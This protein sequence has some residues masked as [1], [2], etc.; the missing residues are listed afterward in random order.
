[1]C[2][3]RLG[4]VSTS[5]AIDIDWSINHPDY[6]EMS[7]VRNFEERPS[8]RTPAV[9]APRGPGDGRLPAV[10]VQADG[11]GLAGSK[12]RIPLE[13]PCVHGA[14]VARR[15]G[16]RHA[17]RAA[18]GEHLPEPTMG[19]SARNA[20]QGGA[21][22]PREAAGR[23]NATELRAARSS[24]NVRPVSLPGSRDCTKR[25]P[26]R[27]PRPQMPCRPRPTPLRLTP[28]TPTPSESRPHRASGRARRT[29]FRRAALA[30]GSSRTP[31]ASRTGDP[32]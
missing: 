29:G 10:R 14:P 17:A 15:L 25:Y 30:P 8:A 7:G 3:K 31:P 5:A 12:A 11:P 22:R 9:G 21:A 18:G 23:G 27:A 20:R 1:M 19:T 28:L 4:S 13:F 16:R 2:R 32:A 24:S 6:R 26:S